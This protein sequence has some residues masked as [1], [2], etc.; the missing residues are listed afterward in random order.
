LLEEGFVWFISIQNVLKFKYHAVVRTPHPVHFNYQNLPLYTGD[1]PDFAINRAAL[2]LKCG[3]ELIT[4][5]SMRPMPIERVK[6]DPV[7]IGW[8]SDPNFEYPKRGAEGVVIAIWDNDK[9]LE[10]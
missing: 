7:L 8:E 1:I 9:E 5:H 2:A 10:L 6:T 4:I 3:L